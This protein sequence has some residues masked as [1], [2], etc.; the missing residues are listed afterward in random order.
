M[1]AIKPFAGVMFDNPKPAGGD[2]NKV[3]RMA[4]TSAPPNR[5]PAQ[6]A[7]LKRSLT[8]P[9]LTLYGLGVTI[10][11][12]IYVLVGAAAAKAGMYAPVSFIIAAGAVA[13]TGLSYSE[14]G[15]RFPVSAGEAAYV[16]EG[17]RSPALSLIVGLMVAAS[18]IISSAAVAIGAAAYIHQFVPLPPDLLAALVIALVGLVA[19]WGIF[20]SVSI[21]ALFTLVE[22]GG[23][24]F[25]VYYGLS[26]NPDALQNAADLIPP[27]EAGAWAGIFSASLLAFFAFVGF[28]DIAN[29][30]EEAVRPARNMPLAIILTLIIATAFYVAVVAVTVLVVPL[31]ELSVSAAPLALVFGPAGPLTA[32]IFRIIAIIATVNGI[33]IQ[34]IMASRVIYGLADQGSLPGILG[35]VSPLTRTPLVATAAVVAIVLA[36]AL[37]VPIAELAE[38]T[39]RVVL[40]VFA[41]VN[42]ALLRLKWTAAASDREVFT[43]PAWIPVAGLLA[44]ALL[45]L[46]DLF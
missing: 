15:T 29:V 28:E 42:L 35:R 20:E 34:I 19:A 10:G 27:F 30:A 37:L 33:L 36:L 24:C 7:T 40:T 5:E 16:R 44:S 3:Y 13:F 26:A 17:F 11:A 4:E 21:A 22:V 25:V 6:R 46:A 2:R 8:L 31:D 9:L 45:L 12:G 18:G 32:T 23:L 41:M 14:L 1:I 43:V 38:T 39:S